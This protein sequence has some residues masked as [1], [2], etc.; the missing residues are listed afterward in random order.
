MRF[1]HDD[2][3]EMS[4]NGATSRGKPQEKF[5]RTSRPI[6]TQNT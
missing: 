6:N 2:L 1:M 4:E 3:V 5:K